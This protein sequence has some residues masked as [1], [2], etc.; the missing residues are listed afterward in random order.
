MHKGPFGRA[1]ARTG[2]NRHSSRRARR[3]PDTRSVTPI[4]I[5]N[6]SLS[7]FPIYAALG[8]PE[9]WR[10]DGTRVQMFRLSGGSYV[11]ADESHFFPRVTC[12]MLLEFLELNK[13]RGQTET[14]KLFRQRIQTR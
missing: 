1:I 13:T 9:I 12:S 11:G 5:T 6:E 7:K 4:D 8:V 3:A 10:Y 2:C 14:L